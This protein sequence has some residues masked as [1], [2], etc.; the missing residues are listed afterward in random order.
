ML[1]AED[2][3]ASRTLLFKFLSKYGECDLTVDGMQ[4]LDAYLMSLDDNNPYE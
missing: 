3:Y 4:A 2:D 1:I